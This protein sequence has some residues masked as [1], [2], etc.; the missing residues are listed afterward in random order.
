MDEHSERR[1]YYSKDTEASLSEAILEAVEAHENASLGEDEFT[2]YDHVNPDAIDMLFKDTTDIAVSVQI[3]LTNVTVSIWS[4]G[5]IDIRDTDK[6][7]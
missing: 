2:L 5:G 3:H 6:I 7:D 4:D 1:R